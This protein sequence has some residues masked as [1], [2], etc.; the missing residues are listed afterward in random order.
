M[1]ILFIILGCVGLLLILYLFLTF[2]AVRRHPHRGLL[3]GMLIAHRGLHDLQENTPENSL[4]AFRAGIHYRLAIEI[5]IH[6][7]ADGEVVVFHDSDL[8]RMCGVEGTVETQTFE[9]LR[10]Y[11]LNGTEE[12]IPSLAECLKTVN[13]AVPLMIELKCDGSNWQA[14]CTAANALLSQYK[15]TY[16]VQSFYPL[17]LWWYRKHRKDICRGQ[18]STAFPH[19]PVHHRLLGLLLFNF[20]ARPDFVSYDHHYANRFPLIL[21]I[22]LGAFPVGWTFTSQKRMD[23]CRIRY[24]TCIFEGFFPDPQQQTARP[25]IKR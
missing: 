13:G 11:R 18:L 10:R 5:D 7:T 4:A 21:N 1:D 3:D 9:Q 24:R 23:A 25:L 22:W 8:K 6:L 14:L 2:P 12:Q 19:G 15:G 20:L 17:A 16:F